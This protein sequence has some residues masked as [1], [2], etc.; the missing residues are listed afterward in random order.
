MAAT[1]PN[2]SSN[3]RAFMMC[4]ESTA[5]SRTTTFGGL[6]DK[7]GGRKCLGQ[8]GATNDNGAEGKIA[9][10]SRLGGLPNVYHPDAT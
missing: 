8:V 9:C 3:G 5:F 6:D 2:A 7:F 1:I 4:M 10:R